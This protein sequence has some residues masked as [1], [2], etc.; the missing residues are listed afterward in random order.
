VL[1]ENLTTL[2][3]GPAGNRIWVNPS[4]ITLVRAARNGRRR[5][6]IRRR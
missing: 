1:N 3:E 6:H 4:S 5:A 2:L